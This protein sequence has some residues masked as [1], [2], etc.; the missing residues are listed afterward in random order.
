MVRSRILGM[1][2]YVPSR[3]VKNTELE[4]L[5]DTSDEWI[6]KRTG[7]RER[8]WAAPDEVTSDLGLKASLKALENAQLKKEDI[9]CLI[10]ATLSPD[11]DFPGTGCF[12]QAK[13]DVPGIPALDIREQCSG[14][15]Y[16]MAVADNFIRTGMYK[17]ILV[18]GSEVHSRGL[19]R[20]PR[21][22]DVSVIF[23][24]GAGAV[25]L[26]ATEVKDPE[27][28]A[29]LYSNHLHA[30]GRFARE[31]WM[32]APGFANA[33]ESR[34]DEAMLAQGL[35]YPQMNGKKVF[36]HAVEK[37]GIVLGE[38]L[39]ANGLQSSDIDM[40]FFHQANLRINEAVGEALKIPAEKVFNTIQKY[41]NTTAATIPLGMDEARKEGRLK[42]GML[43]AT[44]AFGSGF[45][46][47]AS[48]LRY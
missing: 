28:D 32:A 33:P 11:H 29:Y 22:R 47:G 46:W 34:I 37:M 12:L 30:D 5:M 8:R 31:L 38:A 45:T 41:G 43:I 17:R 44:T 4:K 9:E 6:T 7:I 21:G 35:H 19:D 48:I 20:T 10:F 2:S 3:V 18:V 16:S 23:G 40:F 39:Q 36:M 25:V 1:G 26:G 15:I 27:K 13:L 24:D 42:P 14:F